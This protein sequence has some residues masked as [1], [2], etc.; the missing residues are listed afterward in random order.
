MQ[1]W[2]DTV[3]PTLAYGFGAYNIMKSQDGSIESACYLTEFQP[4]DQQGKP[5]KVHKMILQNINTSGGVGQGSWDMAL[6]GG[7]VGDFNKGC[8]NQW[9]TDWGKQYGGVSTE[10][11][12]CKMPASLRSSCLFRFT[13]FGNNPSLA[14]A[15]KRVRCPVGIIDRSGSQRQD[16]AQTPAYNGRTDNTGRPA[17]DKYQ[18][19]RGVCQNL[20]PL[21]VVSAVCGGR[22]PKGSGMIRQDEPVPEQTSPLKS[23]HGQSSQPA[24]YGLPPSGGA[25]SVGQMSPQLPGTFNQPGPFSLRHRRT[26]SH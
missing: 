18:R 13:V 11:D 26:C 1:P 9:G 10:Q 14:S 15:S 17:P 25:P 22:L 7:G 16:D 8:R 5:M 12:C 6:A 23:P 21:G 24:D 2:V 4:Q 3:D 19:Q 20:D